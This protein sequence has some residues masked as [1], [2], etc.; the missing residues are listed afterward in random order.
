MC[1]DTS[2]NSLQATNDVFFIHNGDQ[3][4]A[5]ARPSFESVRQGN[6]AKV[7]MD[8]TAEFGTIEPQSG[9]NSLVCQQLFVSI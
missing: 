2:V 4:N 5:T 3:S 8:T 9:A 7:P 6:H 1:L